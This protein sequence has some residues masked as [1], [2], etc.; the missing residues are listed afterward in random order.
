MSESKKRSKASRISEKYLNSFYD[1]VHQTYLSILKERPDYILVPFRGADPIL[2]GVQ[3]LASIDRNSSK[4]PRVIP[5][6]IGEISREKSTHPYSFREDEKI[7]EIGRRLQ[8][9]KGLK[10]TPKLIIV[11]EVQKG[12]SMS[13]NFGY[14]ENALRRMGISAELSGIGIAETGTPRHERF[15]VLEQQGKIKPIFVEKLFTVDKQVF[16]PEIRRTDSNSTHISSHNLNERMEIFEKLQQMHMERYHPDTLR[17][18]NE[19]RTLPRSKRK[20]VQRRK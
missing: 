8:R 6:L 5:L 20:P 3:L 11:D 10:G 2:K 15:S 13:K 17:E 12:G 16:L 9:L 7:A 1:A 4:M 18:I 19:A 14:V